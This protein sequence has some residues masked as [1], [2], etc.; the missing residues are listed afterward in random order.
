MFNFLSKIENLIKS[1]LLMLTVI[2]IHDKKH[3]S[4]YFICTIPQFKIWE[5]LS[6]RNY[7]R[8]I[9]K[10]FLLSV[11]AKQYIYLNIFTYL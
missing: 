5:M 8:T 4:V 11:K 2:L 10:F 1:C 9:K 7:K 3:E 6:V